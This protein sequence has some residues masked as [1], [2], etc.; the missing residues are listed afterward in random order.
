MTSK[1]DIKCITSL[2]ESDI[3]NAL[4][5][6]YGKDCLIGIEH[7]HDEDPVPSKYWTAKT[8]TDIVNLFSHFIL[9][10]QNDLKKCEGRICG[11]IMKRLDHV[12]LSIFSITCANSIEYEFRV[13]INPERLDELYTGLQSL[14][15]PRDESCCAVDDENDDDNENEGDPSG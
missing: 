12:L 2:T 10:V 8:S 6:K 3:V 9:S 4:W 14:N 1:G 5:E 7:C 11:K 15:L 13:Y